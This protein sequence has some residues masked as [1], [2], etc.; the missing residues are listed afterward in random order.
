[1]NT[2]RLGKIPGVIVPVMAK[3]SRATLKKHDALA[4]L[5]SR[6][7]AVPFL[8]RPPGFHNGR[9]FFKI[10]NAR[11]LT[12]A[13]EAMPGEDIMA[14]QFLDARH[15]DGKIRKFRVM[16]IDGEI[17][18]LHAAVGHQWKIH[19]VTADMEDVPEHR[20]EDAAFLNDMPARLGSRAMTALEGIRDALGLD[21]AG[22]DFSL[23]ADG[24]IL[25]FEANATMVVYPPAADE[26]WTYRRAPVE[27][28][29]QAIRRMLTSHA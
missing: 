10:E 27:R 22:V 9:H 2:E 3:V 13:L 23:N 8:L 17:Y 1:M 18:P 5:A 4:V 19:Y 26:K 6:G 7:F 28:I 24:D 16:M 14:I 29:S 12:M 11:D 20:A 15:N 25:L 21:Y